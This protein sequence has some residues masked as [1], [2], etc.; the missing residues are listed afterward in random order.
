M[1]RFLCFTALFA[2]QTVMFAGVELVRIIGDPGPILTEP[3]RFASKS[4]VEENSEN[5]EEL[6]ENVRAIVGDVYSGNIG[7]GE[8]I[9]SFLRECTARQRPGVYTNGIQYCLCVAKREVLS[10]VFE[11]LRAIPETTSNANASEIVVRFSMKFGLNKLEEAFCRRIFFAETRMSNREFGQVAVVPDFAFSNRLAESDVGLDKI[12]QFIDSAS[13][14]D[15]AYVSSMP[16]IVVV[17]R[18]CF[19]SGLDEKQIERLAAAY[20]KLISRRKHPSSLYALGLLSEEF[21]NSSGFYDFLKTLQSLFRMDDT[22]IPTQKIG[23]AA[24]E[25]E[26]LS[27]S[28]EIGRLMRKCRFEVVKSA[29]DIKVEV[30]RKGLSNGRSQ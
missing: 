21:G 17:L 25:T 3:E 5:L 23:F 22:A 6:F 11:K 28:A 19:I 13:S 7:N 20:C 26:V 16:K 9:A 8:F 12:F 2:C 14:D 1:W 27:A 4:G 10:A 18:D 24:A 29:D 30:R 15:M